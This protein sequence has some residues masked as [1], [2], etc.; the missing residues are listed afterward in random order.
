MHAGSVL[1]ALLA[2]AGRVSAEEKAPAGPGP[3]PM[4]YPNVAATAPRDAASGQASGKRQHMPVRMRAY[5]DQSIRL[6][7]GRVFLLNTKTGE[8]EFGDGTKGDTPP[9]GEVPID[10]A[11]RKGNGETL[12]VKA[13]RLV[14]SRATPFKT[15][16]R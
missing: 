3:V 10:G 2:F 4:P 5:F 7:D 14:T 6:A 13:G 12:H 9:T 1:L 16:A 15:P 8:V 11:Y